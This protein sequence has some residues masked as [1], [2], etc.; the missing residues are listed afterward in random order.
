VTGHPTVA[1][2]GAGMG[3]LAAAHLL[4][5]NHV[6]YLVIERAHRPGGRV[7][8][9]KVDGLL[10]DRGFQVVLEDYPELRRL[11]PLG[12][13]PF[14]RLYPGLYAM[15]DEGA[16]VLVSD[17]RRVPGVL[18]ETFAA[19]ARARGPIDPAALLRLLRGPTR[20]VRDLVDS[21]PA[22][23]GER[24]L[25]PLARGVTLDPALSAPLAE[26]AFVL[27]RFLH[28]PVSLPAGGMAALPA[29]LA[30]SLPA[31][32]FRY[33]E[34]VVRIASGR[35]ELAG[36]E[37]LT[38]DWTVLAVDLP[39]LAQLLK[40]PSPRMRHVGCAHLVGE[41][42]A[43][44]VPAVL[45]PPLDS[46]IWTIAQP[47]AVSLDY[48]DGDPSRHLVSVSMDPSLEPGDLHRELARLLPALSAYELVAHE[49]IANALPAERRRGP[50]LARG[51]LVAGDF[52]GQPSMN[53][54]L[55]SAREAVEHI[56]REL[57]GRR[58]VAAVA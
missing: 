51:V 58:R 24:L 31:E 35:L 25:G 9:D 32:R 40:E 21:L 11:L 53:T 34:E 43:L 44:Q 6:D 8:T 4:E 46:P 15:L 17:P 18:Q 5:R 12:L 49:L 38:P 42:P 26:F 13:V 14:E 2:V 7:A 41:E 3:G 23:V 50:V 29:Q 52:L 48:V 1:I 37:V 55:R 30:D 16:P 39:S 45:V 20:T 57:H 56:L 19:L 28:G 33:D 36:G 10:L 47:S 54:A 22:L 27:A